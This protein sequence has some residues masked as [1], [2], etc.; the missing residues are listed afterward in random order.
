[1]TGKERMLKTLRFEQPD[2]PPHFETM[3]ELEKEAFGLEFPVRH[4]W[5]GCSAAEKS[6]M[7]GQ[8]M[9]IY[10]LEVFREYCQDTRTIEGTET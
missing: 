6:R 2:R 3:F 5:D 1:M 7:I 9:K 8:C 4:A 10:M